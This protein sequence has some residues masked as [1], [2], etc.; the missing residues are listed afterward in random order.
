MSVVDDQQAGTGGSPADCANSRPGGDHAGPEVGRC[1]PGPSATFQQMHLRASGRVDPIGPLPARARRIAAAQT[2][3]RYD[4]LSSWRN[5]IGE[6]S[7]A[8]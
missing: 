2:A 1:G 6:S 7:A 3:R 4:G 8:P 5:S